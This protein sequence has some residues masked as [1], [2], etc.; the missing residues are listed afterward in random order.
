MNLV[1]YNE[2]TCYLKTGKVDFAVIQS[3]E[4]RFVAEWCVP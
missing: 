4:Y 2:V 1:L 3:V